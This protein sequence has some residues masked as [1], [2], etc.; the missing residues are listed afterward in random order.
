MHIAR[1]DELC[2]ASVI[3]SHWCS[4]REPF[5]RHLTGIDRNR[6]NERKPG[7]PENGFVSPTQSVLCVRL[8][9][10]DQWVEDW[11]RACCSTLFTRTARHP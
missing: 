3:M 11:V 8:L 9:N 6:D 4:S 7:P 10:V 5:P 1:L 2:V